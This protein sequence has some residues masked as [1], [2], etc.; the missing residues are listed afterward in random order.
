V[1]PGPG[2]EAPVTELL[3]DWRSGDQKAFDRLMTVLYDQLRVMAHRQMLRERPDHTLR[4]T[5][6]VHEACLKLLSADVPW[7]DRA[8]F[9]AVAAK[10]M[11][12]ILVD[13]ARTRNREKR[14]FDAVHLPLDEALAVSSQP[15]ADLVLLD[16]TLTRLA[17]FDGRKAEIVELLFFGGLT[18]EEAARCL[19]T[20]RATLHRELRLAKAWLYHEISDAHA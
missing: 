15:P 9:L 2:Q 17:S 13:S 12:R 11:R 4:T 18:Y 16:E 3:R 14:G 19:G 5:A 8:H 20:S 7:E 6:L 10:A 1:D